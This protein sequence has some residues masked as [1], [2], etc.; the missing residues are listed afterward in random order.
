[1]LR[2]PNRVIV[3]GG[4]LVRGLVA[5]FSLRPVV[6]GLHRAMAEHVNFSGYSIA[7]PKQ[8]LQSAALEDC[9]AVAALSTQ[10]TFDVLD[11]L[12][13]VERFK[14]SAG[15]NSLIQLI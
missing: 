14:Y 5:D 2:D 12:G 7:T 11:G 15:G 6:R 4:N 1:M 3:P 8:A 9:R 13:G 10:P